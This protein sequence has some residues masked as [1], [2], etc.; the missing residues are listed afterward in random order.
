MSNKP[1]IESIVSSESVLDMWKEVAAEYEYYDND[2][3]K[4]SEVAEIL[5]EDFSGSKFGH[6]GIRIEGSIV[7][8]QTIL[9]YLKPLLQYE[10]DGLSIHMNKLLNSE[11]SQPLNSRQEHYV[12][13]LRL[14][15]PIVKTIKL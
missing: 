4:L 13:Y 10:N 14:V 12:V 5:P 2:D 15:K 7:Y 8:I 1:K 9:R 3:K 6:D 11:I